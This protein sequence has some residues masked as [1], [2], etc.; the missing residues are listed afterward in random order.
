MKLPLVSIIITLYNKERT[1]ERAIKSALSQTYDKTE[2]IVINDCCTDSS[3][4]ICEKY[5]KHITVIHNSRNL[6]LYNSRIKAV[7]TATGEFVTFL[8]ADDWLDHDAI[9]KSVMVAEKT[10]ADVVQMKILRRITKFNVPIRFKSKYDTSKALDACLYDDSIFPVSCCSKLYR[11]Q[12]LQTATFPE[13]DQFWGE[14][15]IFNL[16]VLPQTHN[17][18][19]SPLSVY[20]YS[21]GGTSL[22]QFDTT[23]LQQ[24]KH[25][26]SIKSHWAEKHNLSTLIPRM[27]VELTEL[28]KYHIRHMID[29]EE[30]SDAQMADYLSAELSSDFWSGFNLPSVH[31]IY[32]SLLFSPKRKL[33]R[34]I[35]QWL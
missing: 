26:F 22:S 31:A 21:W 8:D 23:A 14:D 17:I 4:M 9:T 12:I 13:F 33:K 3:L 27:R 24:Y 28:L 1:I 25:V 6:G 18:A 11:K 35:R 16:S 19:L 20:N 10:N 29:S 15:R 2:I 30:Y 32:Q 7:K 34:M 5:A